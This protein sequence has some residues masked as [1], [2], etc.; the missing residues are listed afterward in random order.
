MTQ[1]AL[2]NDCSIYDA[3]NKTV[4]S[5]PLFS[6]IDYES[7]DD[8]DPSH[9]RDVIKYLI[10]IGYDLEES[11]VF[12]QTPLLLAATDVDPATTIL[13]ELF[14]ERGARLDTK[15]GFGLGLL[16]TVLL[17]YLYLMDLGNDI[18]PDDESKTLKTAY[19]HMFQD[20][21]SGVPD[22]RDMYWGMSQLLRQ[23]YVEEC[24][25][26]ESV[27]DYFP[28]LK[29]NSVYNSTPSNTSAMNDWFMLRR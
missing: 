20:W 5:G 25:P 24:R 3:D 26:Q 13:M 6:I 28:I 21:N 16:H 12:G 15:D 18:R 27:R 7:M 4:L 10:S 11:N 17:R 8:L 22:V 1:L 23:D 14:I 9:M 29:S 19:G 2:D